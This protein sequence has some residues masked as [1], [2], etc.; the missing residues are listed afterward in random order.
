M[1]RSLLKGQ[2]ARWYLTDVGLPIVVV[3]AVVVP[4]R[5][6]MPDALSLAARAAWMGSTVPLALAAAV[7][8]LPAGRAWVTQALAGVTSR[9]AAAR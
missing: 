9:Q 6:L 1:H 4:G 3:S 8:A 2:L 7:L 5:L